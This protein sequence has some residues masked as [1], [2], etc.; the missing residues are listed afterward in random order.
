MND[1]A[2]NK[3]RLPE[4]SYAGAVGL[5]DGKRQHLKHPS[6]TKQLEFKLSKFD[7]TC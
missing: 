1:V 2:W 7:D 6:Q 4:K 5:C 3:N